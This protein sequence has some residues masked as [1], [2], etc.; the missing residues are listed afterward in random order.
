MKFLILPQQGR[1]GSQPSEATIM[2]TNSSRNTS[3]GVGRGR[4]GHSTSRSGR[5]LTQMKPTYYQPDEWDNLTLQQKQM[6]RDLLAKQDKKRSIGA[7]QMGDS[8]RQQ[9]EED[10]KEDD[11]NKNDNTNPHSIG[12]V[13]SQ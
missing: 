9:K 11:K 3:R 7:T 5:G 2:S 12:S 13:M 6:A 8:K 4:G 1:Q 10:S